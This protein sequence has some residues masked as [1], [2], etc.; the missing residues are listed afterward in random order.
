MTES[1]RSAGDSS[2]SV[3]TPEGIQF[4]LYPA[5][6][7]VR[8]CAFA[9]DEIIQWVFIL[10]I[11]I[12]SLPVSGFTGIWL[13]LLIVFGINWFYHVFCELL[14]RGQSIGKRIFGIRVVRSDGSPVNPGASFLRNLLRF[15]DNF[16]FLCLIA[17]LCISLS[18]G[19]RRIGDWA[20]DTLVVYTA[21]AGSLARRNPMSWIGNVEFVSPSRPLSYEE[22]QTILMFARRYPLLGVSRADEIARDYAACLRGS[23]ADSRRDSDYLLGIARRLSGDSL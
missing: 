1:R 6:F 8:A 22:K 4:A 23:A 13:S 3:E 11:A 14:F 5:G 19:F 2:F 9:V 12:V 20:A 17:L 15:A 16:M 18:R 10:V 7:L 21:G